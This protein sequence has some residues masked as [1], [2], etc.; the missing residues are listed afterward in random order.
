M[1]TQGTITDRYEIAEEIARGGMGT[2]HVAWDRALSR[3]V[4]VKLMRSEAPQGG[5]VQP[6]GLARRF[7][8]EVML[9]A[10]L[11]HPAIVP[12]YDAAVLEDGT[13]F[14]AM[15]L[16]AGKTLDRAVADAPTIPERLG[17]VPNVLAVAEAIAYAHSERVVHRDLKPQNVLVGRFGET[18]VL[19]WGLAKDIGHDPVEATDALTTADVEADRNVSVA[20]SVVGTLAYMP[21]ERMRGEPSDERGDVYG[22]GCILYQVIA[23][24]VPRR[25]A[26]DEPEPLRRRQPGVPAELEAIVNK[27]M[28]HTAAD[29]YP[30]AKEL[31]DDLRKFQ[32]G[33]LVGAH[34]YSAW[35]LLRRWIRRHRTLVAVAAV[36]VVLGL[37]G[38]TRIVREQARTEQSRRDAE[39]LMTFMLGSLSKKLEPLGKLDVLDDV[40]KKAV[41]YYDQREP[42]ATEADL[43]TRALAQRDLGDVLAAQGHADEA[44]RQ[45]RSALAIDETLTASN[46]TNSNWQRDLSATH[47][48]LGD[49]LS[50]QGDS[51]GALA[52]YRTAQAIDTTLAASDPT[53]V[54][55]QRDLSGSHDKIGNVLITQGDS[56]NG[57]R[58]FRAALAI[59]ETLPPS[60]EQQRDVSVSHDNVGNVL[61]E[62]GDSVG[63]LA[64]YRASLA[65]AETLAASD[66]TNASWKGDLIVSHFHI[67]DV[68]E[69]KADRAGALV[70]YRAAKVIAETLAA[71]D[72]TNADRQADLASAH[73]SV[74]DVLDELGDRASALV[75]YRAELAIATTLAASDPINAER[76][77]QLVSGHSRVGKVLAQ[78]G[79]H[80]GALVEFRAQL[81][82]AMTVA[83]S[84]PTNADRQQQLL[85]S[86]NNVGDMIL[87]QGNTAN[88]LVEYR[89]ALAIAETLA[90][91]DPTNADRQPDLAACHVS[92]GDALL[93]SGDKAGAL[94]EYRTKLTIDETLAASWIRTNVFN[95]QRQLLLSHSRVGDAALA[96]RDTAT[97]LAE[98]RASLA[99]AETL[100]STDPTNA[101]RQPD[102]SSSHEDLGDALLAANTP[103]ALAEYDAAVAIAQRLQDADP[104]NA[105]LRKRATSL[106]TKVAS[107]CRAHPP[108]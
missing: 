20:G 11:Q 60:A 34:R 31:A 54:R 43:A 49:V 6:T 100:A 50:A 47:T 76:Q 48:E 5:D 4:A 22:L 67:G 103:G 9:T 18:V 104:T 36:A 27:A 68:L 2:V 15:R 96:Q 89:A 66:P 81:A 1:P 77:V 59:R 55:R 56:A 26:G 86:H 37:I 38:V 105:H 84:D 94:A 32:T 8:R 57:L 3:K 29:R 90:A 12:I 108:R 44:L 35:Q 61:A 93:T 80:A 53:N 87:A 63:A 62:L 91:T 74:G 45:Y 39:E 25:R 88:A 95:Q 65:M 33:Q 99:I 64:E 82:I 85:V 40:A 28:A 71:S 107:C 70:E 51:A 52:E 16:V 21:P 58:D 73:G 17:L 92:V 30:T 102:L 7:A 98:Y 46:P 106:A 78:E 79:D 19:D 10:R 72:P 69:A 75:E 24:G 23:G 41:A 83:A 14:Y 42:S 13:P 97:A 101:H